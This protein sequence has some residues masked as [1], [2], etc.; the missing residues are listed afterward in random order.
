LC[1]AELDAIDYPDFEVILVDNRRRLP[2]PDPLPELVA[3]RPRLRIVREPRPGISAARNA[4]VA[5]ARAD[6]VAFTDDDV[7]V[8]RQWLRAIGLRFARDRRMDAV[9]GIILPAELDSPAQIWFERYYGGFSGQRSFLPL[10]LKVLDVTGSAARRARVVVTAPDGQ[11]VRRFAIYGV[12][13]YGA[14]ANMAFRRSALARVTGFDVALG[15]GTQSRGGEDLATLISVLWHGG[16]VGYEPAAVVHHRHRREYDEL[17]QQLRG[18]G[19][20]FSAML[21]S[22]IAH[23][24]AHLAG[25]GSQFP[26]ALRQFFKQGAARLRETSRPA[27]GTGGATP[28]YPR[29]LQLHEFSGFPRGPLLYTRSRLKARQW[30]S[31]RNIR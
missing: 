3:G 6:I 28:A 14:G 7:R 1:I 11:E 9:T 10:T 31:S 4:G 13:A 22:L 15:T 2:V 30:G 16:V 24:V 27:T 5:A 23:D 20:G 19:I 21:T 29:E 8:D 25:I 18:N 26:L 17:K 12:G